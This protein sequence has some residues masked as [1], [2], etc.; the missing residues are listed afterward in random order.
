MTD[1]MIE[2]VEI[3]K[4]FG[5]LHVLKGINQHVARGEVVSIIGP[6]GSGKSTFLRC[7]NLLEKPTSGK[8]LFEGEEITGKRVNIDQH[9][10]KMGM[11][12]QHF[13]IFPNLT[14]EQNITMAP[15][16]LKKKTKA[17]A[18]DMAKELLTRVGLLDKIGEHPARLSGGQKQRLSIARVFLKDPPILILDE[19]TSALD[20]ESERLVQESLEKLAHGRT[21]FTIAHRLTTIKGADVIWV[22]TEHGVEEM[23]THD[24][25]LKKGGLYAHLY[26]MY[27]EGEA[28]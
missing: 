21:V 28:V 2:T 25:L 16:L 26:A 27:T 20:N 1:N 6:S 14:V 17:E 15:V 3:T 22:L 9:R 13:N 23:G 7:L 24:E 8:I 4:D 11:V 5:K 10:Q 18:A 19:A 12:F